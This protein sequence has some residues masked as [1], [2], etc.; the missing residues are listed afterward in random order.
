MILPQTI[1]A[2]LKTRTFQKAVVENLF[3]RFLE[4]WACQTI[5]HTP[6]PTPQNMSTIRQVRK[7]L[8]QFSSLRFCLTL[9]VD[10]ARGAGPRPKQRTSYIFSLYE[11]VGQKRF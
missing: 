11:K 6:L 10:L 8:E 4:T 5:G 2:F 9:T 7:K 3:G 1:F